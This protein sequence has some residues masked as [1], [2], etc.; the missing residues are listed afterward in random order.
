MKFEPKIQTQFKKAGWFSGRN[1]EPKLNSI[2]TLDTYPH[3][4]KEFLKQYGNLKVETNI[5]TGKVFLDFTPI[6][7][8]FFKPSSLIEISPYGGMKTYAIAYY[9]TDHLIVECDDEGHIYL[10]GDVTIMLSENFKNGIEK[11]IMEDYSNIKEWHPD[12]KQW[13]SERY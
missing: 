13:K 5:S 2:S 9:P 1:I 7:S 4:A 3:F 11:L 6:F 10:F 8:G 12:I